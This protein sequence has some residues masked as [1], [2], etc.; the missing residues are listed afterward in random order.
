MERPD[1]YKGLAQTYNL[2]FAE[3]PRI[4]D[5]GLLARSLKNK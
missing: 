1:G 2:H 4:M 5:L 3:E